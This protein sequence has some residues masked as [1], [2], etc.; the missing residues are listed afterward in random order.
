MCYFDNKKHTSAT[1]DSLPCDLDFNGDPSSLMSLKLDRRPSEPL[2]CP[3]VFFWG[4]LTPLFD[5]PI[6]RIWNGGLLLLLLLR[7]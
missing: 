4:N 5:F 6:A 1:G 7:G 2:A 3:L